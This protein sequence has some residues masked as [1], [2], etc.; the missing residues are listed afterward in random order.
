ML[1]VNCRT[2]RLCCCSIK[3]DDHFI[4]VRFKWFLQGNIIIIIIIII[5]TINDIFINKMVCGPA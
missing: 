4:V 5:I 2:H 3:I 1:K